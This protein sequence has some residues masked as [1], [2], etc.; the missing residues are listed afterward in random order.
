MSSARISAKEYPAFRAW[1]MRVDQAFS[2]K[3]VVERPANKQGSASPARETTS[4]A[5]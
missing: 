5:R 1:L 4:A 2:R 3:L